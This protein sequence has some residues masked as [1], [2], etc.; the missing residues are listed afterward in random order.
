MRIDL[1][2]HKDHY[3][4]IIYNGL[5]IISIQKLP[6]RSK[7]NLIWTNNNL[8]SIARILL[9]RRR[10]VWKKTISQ[11]EV[12]YLKFKFSPSI[13]SEQRRRYKR[14]QMRLRYAYQWDKKKRWARGYSNSS[15][16]WELWRD[17]ERG[18]KGGERSVDAR[19]AAVVRPKKGTY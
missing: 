10:K 13:Y 18:I 6:K 2:R 5:I 11:N 8:I 9:T 19:I 12:W 15:G 14:T 7:L 3:P 4:I 16:R 1:A 17:S